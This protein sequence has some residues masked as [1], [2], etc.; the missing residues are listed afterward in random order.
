MTTP[1]NRPNTALRVV[2]VQAGV[3]AGASRRD[4]VVANIAQLVD[5]GRTQQVPVIWV[6]GSL[7]GQTAPGR[8]AGTVETANVSFT[9]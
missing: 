4:Q 9:G 8:I 7:D 1:D 6:Q 3:V 2:G 5:Q